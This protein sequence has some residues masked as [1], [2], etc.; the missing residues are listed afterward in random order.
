[1]P[2]KRSRTRTVRKEAQAYANSIIPV[3]RARPPA[4]AGCAGLQIAVRR[5]PK[6]S[7][8]FSQLLE[9]YSQRPKSRGGGSTWIRSRS[10]FPRPQAADRLQGGRTAAA[11]CSTALDKLLEK[12][13]LPRA[14][15]KLGIEFHGDAEGTDSVTS[16]PA[17]GGALMP[18]ALFRSSS[19]LCPG[20][21]RR[22]VVFHVSEAEVAI[23]NGVR[24]DRRHELHAGPAWEVAWDRL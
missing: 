1:M 7:V 13:H 17:G 24:R 16:K 21:H 20:A 2:T 3:A 23:R 15:A 4:A 19:R 8:A 12:E 14:G 18:R 11:T 10:A 22:D 9:A 6:A 5:S